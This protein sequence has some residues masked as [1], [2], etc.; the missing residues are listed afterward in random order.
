MR[1]KALALT[2]GL[3]A[4][5]TAAAAQDLHAYVGAGLRPPVEA[6]IED[7][8]KETGITV[9]A[10]YGGS[11]QLLTRFAETKAGDL[12]IPGTTFYTDKLK[13]LDAVADL[14]VLVVHGPVLAV[15]PGK[16]EAI[17][18]IV[19]L[20]KPGV[21]VGLGDPQA[22][23]LGRTAEDILDKSGQGEAI[24]RNVTVRAAT[25]KQLALYVL[26]GNV[27]AAII[28]ASEAAQ[29][30]GK[31]SVLAIPPDWYEAEYAPVAVLTTSAAPDAAKR[32]ADFLASDAGL[33]TFQRFGFPPAPKM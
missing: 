20:A 14:T 26:D 25:V 32:F 30:P 2:F 29:N 12:F 31:L 9:T 8:R 10:E 22:M 23:A 15:A 6:L 7:F 27:D 1:L 5:Q 24:R 19:D 18:S 21:R 4:L 16:A 11:G 28:G 13:E 3:L 33:A 17:R